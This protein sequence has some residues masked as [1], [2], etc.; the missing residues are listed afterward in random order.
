MNTFDTQVKILGTGA[1]L[2]K[3]IRTNLE[4]EKSVDTSDEWIYSRTGIRA[5][6][7]CSTEGG[8]WPSDMAMHAALQALEG[9]RLTPEQ[10][11]LILF[12][13]VTPDQK[14]PNTASILQQKLGITNHCACLDISAAC[15]GFVYGVN[16][17]ASLIR[18]GQAGKVLVVGSELLSQEIDWTD[19]NVCILFGD[20]CGCAILGEAEA[21]ENSDVYATY[22]GADGSGKEFFNH[23]MGGAV[24]PL[25][26]KH[27]REG[28]H[29]MQMKGNEMFKIASRTL[30]ENARKVL[31]QAGMLPGEVDWLIPH[32][33]NIRIIEAAAKLAD[34]PMEK[35]IVNIEN[36][37]NTS[38]ATVP[39][40]LH[41]S[42]TQGKIRRG[43]VLLFNAFG[44]GLTFASTLLR[45]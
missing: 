31:K 43:D 17:A 27:L 14:L 4:L 7:I 40:A 9:A 12:A 25:T 21:G 8:E 28:N 35:V 19:R 34:F 13:T 10:L 33:A 1:Y 29:F 41:E 24:E 26:I 45:Y 42:I 38:A 37:G 11:D 16:M 3:K 30:A 39:I 23:P 22:F 5:R 15:S 20:G 18:T 6:R 36:Y 32:Q 44:A 2:P